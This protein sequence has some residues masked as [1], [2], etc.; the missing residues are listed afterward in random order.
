MTP[1]TKLKNSIT[2]WLKTQ[3]VFF[4]KLHGGPLQLAGMPDLLVIV[5]GLAVFLE[6]KAGRN[7]PTPLQRAMIRRL[8]E[9]G[10]A[11][12]VVRSL[13][14]A[15]EAIDKVKSGLYAADGD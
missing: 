7:E 15:Q 9:H 10:A 6:L 14:E 3:P 5:G 11:A 4:M 1:E 2:R 12:F 8:R 13:S